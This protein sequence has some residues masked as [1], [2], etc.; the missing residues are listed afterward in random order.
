MGIMER[1]CEGIGK[2]DEMSIRGRLTYIALV[3]GILAVIFVGVGLF[4][5]LDHQPSQ[6]NQKLITLAILSDVVGDAEP[7]YVDI[8]E[9]KVAKKENDLILTI[10]ARENIPKQVGFDEEI[11]YKFLIDVDNDNIHDFEVKMGIVF[12]AGPGAA[13]WKGNEPVK[14]LTHKVFGRTMET[15]LALEEIESPKSF[16]LKV[17]CV[18]PSPW[19]TTVND[20][21]PDNKWARLSLR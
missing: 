5:K 18:S 20:A 2:Q 12:A 1:D 13:L 10:T 16:N 19:G 4:A 9:I 14:V 8:K 7:G 17:Y 21:V 6:E 15:T 3:F 11:I